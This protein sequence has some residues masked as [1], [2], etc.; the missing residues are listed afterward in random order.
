M[1]NVSDEQREAIEQH[2]KFVLLACPG[3]GKTFTVAHR[4]A[5]RLKEQNFSHAGIATLSFTN[6]AHEEISQQLQELGCPAVP[7]YPHFLGTIDHFINTWIFLPFGHLVMNAMNDLRLKDFRGIH[8]TR[9]D[10]NGHGGK[11][12]VTNVT[13]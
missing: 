6:V 11:K 8:G 12:N 7:P 9:P 10:T 1:K 5:K 4:L 13:C 3:S 2:G